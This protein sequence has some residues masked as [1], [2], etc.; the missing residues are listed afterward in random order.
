MTPGGRRAGPRVAAGLDAAGDVRPDP[1][2]G[3]GRIVELGAD[4]G[5][6]G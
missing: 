6:L 3:F 1:F 2:G 5:L 4:P